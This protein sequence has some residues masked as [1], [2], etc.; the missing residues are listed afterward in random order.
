M[1]DPNYLH[2][3]GLFGEPTVEALPD[4]TFLHTFTAATQSLPDGFTVTPEI[5][6]NAERD[7]LIGTVVSDLQFIRGPFKS[8]DEL[9]DQVVAALVGGG[10]RRVE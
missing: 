7:A 8:A 6:A 2:F 5:R 3:S 10:F 9:R 4:G 1:S